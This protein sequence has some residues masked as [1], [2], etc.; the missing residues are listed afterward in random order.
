MRLHAVVLLLMCIFRELYARKFHSSERIHLK[1]K[2]REM[3]YHG[4]N[5]YMEHAFPWDELKPLT[6][7]GRRWDRRE[8]GDLDQT[9]GGFS[10]TLIDSLDMLAILGD[11]EEFRHA[12]K[13]VI[14]HVT[15]DR[16]VT[17]SVFE[18]AIRVI[19]GLLS[20]HV[21]AS[22]SYVGLMPPSE[23]KSELLDMAIDLATRL[24]P[25]FDT[26]T[27]IPVD[28]INLLHGLNKHGSSLT[29]PAAGSVLVEFSYLSRLSKNPIFEQKARKAVLAV[30]ERRSH[31]DLLGSSID[32][33]SGTWE[34]S[35]VGIG[36][37]TDSF[38]EYLLKY[39]ILTGEASWLEIFNSSYTAV[40]AHT[41]FN[42]LH[43]EV[44]MHHGNRKIRY[45]RISALQAFWPGL[46]VL[47]GDVVNAVKSHD[48][49]FELWVKFGAMP[50]LFDLRGAGV[51]VD[52]ARASPLRPELIESTYHLYQATRDHKYLK[53]GRKLLH[54]IESV[55]RVPCGYA[56]VKDIYTLEVEDR[57]DSY[58]L[59]E[60]IKYLYLLFSDNPSV[61]VP[62]I[63]VG[64]IHTTLN[65]SVFGT[66]NCID[67]EGYWTR[68]VKSSQVIFS[69]E[70]HIL[71]TAPELYRRNPSHRMSNSYQ[72]QSS[73]GF[74]DHLVDSLSSKKSSFSGYMP[75]GLSVR[76]KNIHVGTIL[77][78]PAK[79]GKQ[80]YNTKVTVESLFDLEPVGN[81]C[82]TISPSSLL[83][84]RIFGKLVMVYRGNC[85][86]ARKALNLEQAGASGVI[87]I[88]TARVPY[89]KY[90]NQ[91][92]L[93][94]DDRSKA[95][96]N[97]SIPVLMVLAEDVTRLVG[98]IRDQELNSILTTRNGIKNEI[99]TLEDEEDGIVASLSSWLW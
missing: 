62:S 73:T 72:C 15:F 50:E 79:F 33:L 25:A 27:G 8:R 96:R 36:A 66:S 82:D 41:K 84:E 6:C 65:V 91:F 68:P 85:T 13:L 46:Q 70:G 34:S 39:H 87:I 54:D 71:L 20:A 5:N 23:Y 3:F 80:I 67:G 45:P 98:L 12:V 51:V 40:E 16:N 86:F 30:W 55:S 95:G 19:G 18:S 10:L 53:I 59:S 31:L 4:Y 83:G 92:Y 24:L 89:K 35:H 88:N 74:D 14:Q 52:W 37:G 69:T 81:G 77:A 32:V 60:T 44:D 11:H 28:R 93:I 7:E 29:C 49:L 78:S 56:A 43:V 63:Y 2:A 9:L 94:W 17:V 1:N 48:R 57:M 75:L 58:F 99:P 64:S 76:H 47:A 22:S 21:L 90:R 42:D 97:V 38:Y 26:P 61:I